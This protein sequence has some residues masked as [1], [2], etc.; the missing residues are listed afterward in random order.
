MKQRLEAR[1][2]GGVHG[3]NFRNFVKEKAQTLGLMGW[4]KNERD[5]TVAVVAEGEEE[6]L[7]TFEKLL[8]KG[9]LFAK[10]T[11]VDLE[12]GE[13]SG[14]FNSFEIRYL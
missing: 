12:H 4:V 7:K 10:V 14:E 8:W 3:V 9:P 1:I 6:N 2:S 5:G 11:G 13:A